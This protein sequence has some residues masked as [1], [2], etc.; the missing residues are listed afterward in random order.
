MGG[1]GGAQT[2]GRYREALAGSFKLRLQKCNRAV[3]VSLNGHLRTF[4]GLVNH[5]GQLHK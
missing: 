2:C 4:E 5:T 1:S 3:N